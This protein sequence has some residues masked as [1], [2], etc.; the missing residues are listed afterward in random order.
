[1]G[2][3]FTSEVVD[4]IEEIVEG[5]ILSVESDSDYRGSEL[6]SQLEEAHS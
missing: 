1:M 6:S 5:K 2:E 3:E 4:R